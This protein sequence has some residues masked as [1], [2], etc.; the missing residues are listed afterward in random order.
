MS[1]VGKEHINIED[2]LSLES[3]DF[4]I[5]SEEIKYNDNK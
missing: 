2:D 5:I 3:L 4:S 1:K